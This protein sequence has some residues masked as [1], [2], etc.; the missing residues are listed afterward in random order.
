[1]TSLKE[2]DIVYAL[3]E[4]GAQR[5]LSALVAYLRSRHNYLDDELANLLD[6]TCNSVWQLRLVRRD[7][8]HVEDAVTVERKAAAYQRTQELTGLIADR[9]LIDGIVK[10]LQAKWRRSN[11]KVEP[12][13]TRW[14]LQEEG[15]TIA[16]I[17]SDKQMTEAAAKKIAAAEYGFT[18]DAF[19]DVYRDLERDMRA[20]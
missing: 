19:R 1:M 15:V 12:R 6:E 11:W 10:G 9:A 16:N 4:P 13:K 17:A 5:N 18:Y 7:T 20:E 14:L 3:T 8:R 2:I